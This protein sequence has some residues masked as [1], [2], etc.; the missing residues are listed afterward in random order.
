M[1]TV[2]S[3]FSRVLLVL[4]LLII[5]DTFGDTVAGAAAAAITTSSTADAQRVDNRALSISLICGLPVC[6]I[7]LLALIIVWHRLGGA[8]DTHSPADPLASSV[9]SLVESRKATPRTS[10]STVDLVCSSKSDDVQSASTTTSA[11]APL[12]SPHPSSS[13]QYARGAETVFLSSN[14]TRFEAPAGASLSYIGCN[15]QFPE[16]TETA[17]LS[18]YTTALGGADSSYGVD[19]S[20]RV[21]NTSQLM[22]VEAETTVSENIHVPE[23]AG[24]TDATHHP[25]HDIAEVSPD[26]VAP[27]SPRSLSDV[28]CIENAVQPS[29]AET[30][31]LSSYTTA[32]GLDGPSFADDSDVAWQMSN[33]SRSALLET[34][35]L[36]NTSALLQVACIGSAGQ[37]P[38][39]E[40]TETTSLSSYITAPDSDS[41]LLQ[42]EG[43]DFTSQTSNTSQSGATSSSSNPSP[44][45]ESACIAHTS[46][47]AL[48]ETDTTSLSSDSAMASPRSS[49]SLLE[50]AGANDVSHQAPAEV[51][52]ATVLSSDT[53]TLDAPDPFQ[54]DDLRRAS[55]HTLVDNS[56]SSSDTLVPVR[57]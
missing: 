13:S 11:T 32:P 34:S 50:V 20:G 29:L 10:L 40:V 8:N 52:D 14:T 48:V 6:C 22:L 37:P 51:S 55:Q 21:D 57:P 38:L 31:S 43:V 25:L 33:T 16:V 7:A 5:W 41:T 2:S 3:L 46:I 12:G 9:G 47:S 39:G 17:S 15:S 45:S 19:A 18:S 1:S 35:L 27:Q 54:A 23:V 36:S 53:A 30:A 24:T 42:D 26:L 4:S 44:P 56:W 49:L 28:T